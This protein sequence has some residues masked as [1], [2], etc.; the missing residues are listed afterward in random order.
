MTGWCTTPLRVHTRNRQLSA[1]QKQSNNNFLRIIT[2]LHKLQLRQPRLSNSEY[3]SAL[4][5]LQ[6]ELEALQ[7]VANKSWLIK[8]MAV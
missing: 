4:S 6:K 3:L 1:Y 8:K 5:N 2:K 7:A